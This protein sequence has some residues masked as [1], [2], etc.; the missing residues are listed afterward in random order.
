MKTISPDPSKFAK[1]T[2]RVALRDDT[3][4]GFLELV[5]CKSGGRAPRADSR[6][7]REAS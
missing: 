2:Y 6:G 4:Q 5:M 7:R 1:I 3:W